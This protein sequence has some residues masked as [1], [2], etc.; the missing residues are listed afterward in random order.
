MDL[1]AHIDGGSRGNPG[2][3]AIGVIVRDEHGIVLFEE[4]KFIGRATNNEAEYQALIYLLKQ[5]AVEPALANS[6]AEHLRIHCDSKLIVMQVLGK[7][8]IKEPRMQE[9]RD[10]VMRVKST[11]PYE[12]LI[13]HIPRSDNKRADELVNIALDNAMSKK[14]NAI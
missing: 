10:A 13:K 1:I 8:K 3:S 12:P 5:A 9:L 4:G 2:P 6:G 7:W 11:I 14:D